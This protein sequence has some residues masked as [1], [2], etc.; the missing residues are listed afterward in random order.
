MVLNRGTDLLS[1]F[2]PTRM[3]KEYPATNEV[4]EINLKGGSLSEKWNESD[5]MEI[6]NSWKS[7]G[8]SS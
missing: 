6:A 8:K 2:C 1:L 3:D 5:L 4:M 7:I